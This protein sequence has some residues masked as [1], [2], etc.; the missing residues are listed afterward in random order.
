MIKSAIL[1]LTV[2]FEI[3]EVLDPSKGSIIQKITMKSPRTFNM[4]FTHPKKLMQTRINQTQIQKG[5]K[6]AV[7]IPKSNFPNESP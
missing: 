6:I 1:N 2:R 7:E 3:S 4:S 5:I